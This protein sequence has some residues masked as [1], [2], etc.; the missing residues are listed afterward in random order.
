ME[1]ER[2]GGVGTGPRRKRYTSVVD[3]AR[4]TLGDEFA[5]DLKAQMRARVISRLL[6]LRRVCAGLSYSEVARH[7]DGWTAV[8]VESLEDGSDSDLS[9]ADISKF[10]L[11][12]ED[13]KTPGQVDF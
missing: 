6:S 7:V 12:I 3:M 13:A 2:C 9:V 8:F 5:D 4:D 10:L 11:A 1:L